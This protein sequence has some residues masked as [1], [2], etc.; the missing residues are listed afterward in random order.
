MYKDVPLWV[1]T[2][3]IR[4]INHE[5]THAA[6][7]P[8]V[9]IPDSVPS[10]IIACARVLLR[11]RAADVH[12]SIKDVDNDRIVSDFFME[13]GNVRFITLPDGPTTKGRP[14]AITVELSP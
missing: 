12:V 9:P 2:L 1:W 7:Q 5:D 4:V 10:E 14:F 3:L 13:L 8:C 11:L 6:D